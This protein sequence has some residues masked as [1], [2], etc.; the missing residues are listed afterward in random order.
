MKSNTITY[1]HPY[2]VESVTHGIFAGRWLFWK[3]VDLEIG[4]VSNNHIEIPEGWSGKVHKHKV[5]LKRV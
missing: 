3:E 5:V 2:K 4:V 1:A